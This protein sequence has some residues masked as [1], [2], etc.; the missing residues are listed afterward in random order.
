[1]TA[2][3]FTTVFLL[4]LAA[5]VG[6]RLW[7]ARRQVAHVVAHRDAVPSAFAARI[8]VA[9][10]RK[11][12]DY[13]VAKQRLSMLHTGVDAALLLA[14]TLGGGLAAI[15][16]WTQTFALG[17]LWRDVLMFAVAGAVYG[18]VN[19]PFSWWHT[20]RIEERFGFNRMTLGLWLADLAKGSPSRRFS[21]CRCWCSSCG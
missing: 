9:A 16:A 21:G 13:T 10:H 1:M 15:I 11:A 8:G 4:A 18:A 7:L 14:L 17:P 5:S 6:V 12:A 3:A 19:L 20:F 2:P